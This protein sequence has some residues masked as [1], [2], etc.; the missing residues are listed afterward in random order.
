[1]YLMF[2]RE[3]FFTIH[4]YLMAHLVSFILYLSL[5]RAWTYIYLLR[6]ALFAAHFCT[7][8]HPNIPLCQ[9]K[10]DPLV[11]WVCLS[12]C[13]QYYHNMTKPHASIFSKTKTKRQSQW[14]W[15]WNTHIHYYSLRQTHNCRITLWSKFLKV[16]F[17]L[18][19]DNVKL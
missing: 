12:M 17:F 14:Y 7:H 13:I 6:T 8:C 10:M 19:K 5:N 9:V 2:V 3:T 1:M 15:Q 18:K 4:T 16:I 11:C